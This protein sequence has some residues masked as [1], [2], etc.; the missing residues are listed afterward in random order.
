MR[1]CRD[2]RRGE[3]LSLYPVPGHGLDFA[4]AGR[5]NAIDIIDR[6]CAVPQGRAGKAAERAG[7]L[8]T[9]SRH[10]IVAWRQ[11]WRSGFYPVMPLAAAARVS[12]WVSGVVRSWQLRWREL[13]AALR[14][15]TQAALRVIS[16]AVLPGRWFSGARQHRKT[17]RRRRSVSIN[18]QNKRKTG[19]QEG[20]PG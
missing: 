15:L 14:A 5:H 7:P 4:P 13:P 8:L 20:A 11:V 17:S 1:C 9:K 16:T 12:L 19:K 18:V 3:S 6:L 10:G 2:F